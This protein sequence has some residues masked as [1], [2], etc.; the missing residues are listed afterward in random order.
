MTSE[1]AF[2]GR[3]HRKKKQPHLSGGY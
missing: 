1:I 3:I 2:Y